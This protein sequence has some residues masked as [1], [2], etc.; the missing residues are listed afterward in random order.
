MKRKIKILIM[1]IM[2]GIGGFSPMLCCSIGEYCPVSC[3]RLETNSIK[4]TI[5]NRKN[6]KTSVLKNLISN[7]TLKSLAYDSSHFNCYAQHNDNF[8]SFHTPL[9]TIILLA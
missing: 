9:K 2:F 7:D 1:A 6:T 8:P 5:H 3:S 4:T